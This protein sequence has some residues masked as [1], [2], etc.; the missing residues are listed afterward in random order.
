MTVL[1]Y[2]IDARVEFDPADGMVPGKATVPRGEPIVDVRAA[3]K[4]ALAEPLDYPPL[5]R[6][7]TPADRVVVALDHSHPQAAQVTAA[8]IEALIEAGVDPD[9]IAVLQTQADR[10]AGVEDPCRLLPAGVRRRITRLTHDPNDRRQLAYL[11]ASEA[12]EAILI[13][14]ALHEADF[15]LPIGC[16]RHREAAGYFGIHTSIYPAFSDAKTA[17][18]FR[19]LASLN[20]HGERKRELIGMANNVAWLLGVCFTIQVVPGAGDQVLHVL[21]GESD[22]VRRRGRELYHAAW[23]CSVDEQAS[24]VV[25]AIEGSAGQQTWENV[26]RA[27][28]VARRFAEEGGAIA[29]CTELQTEPGPGMQQLA[30][31]ESREVGLKQLRKERP[32]DALSAALVARTLDRHKVYLLSRLDAGAVEDLDM[33]P[34]NDSAELARL[35]RHH[36]SC[37]LLPSAPYVAAVSANHA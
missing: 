37:V 24:L 30:A 3:V 9:G 36:P 20:G 25:A 16:L 21:A 5:A 33:I 13:N 18:R 11:A 2:G 31:A 1:R 7:T 10:D 17:Q 15:V 23:N 34:I 8:S 6:C 35:V 32:V 27:L 26:A 22:A 29:V 19:G 4:A 28:Q 12:G 14:R